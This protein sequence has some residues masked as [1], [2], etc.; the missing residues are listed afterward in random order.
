MF[1]GNLTTLAG[2]EDGQVET[3]EIFGYRRRA[4]TDSGKVEGEFY[5]T[6]YL[7]SYLTEFLAMGI[8]KDGEAYL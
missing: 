2:L 7:P 5:A 1:R 4:T 8:I 6:G 3:R